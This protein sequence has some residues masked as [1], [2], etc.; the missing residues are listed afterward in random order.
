MYWYCGV[1]DSSSV[2]GSGILVGSRKMNEKS[3]SSSGAWRWTPGGSFAQAGHLGSDSNCWL[4]IKWWFWQATHENHRIQVYFIIPLMTSKISAAHQAKWAVNI[5]CFYCVVWHW[6]SVSTFALPSGLE[7]KCWW[8]FVM[9]GSKHRYEHNMPNLKM[10]HI[11]SKFGIRT[12]VKLLIR[13]FT[14]KVSAD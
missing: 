4:Y 2:C 10:S 6:W 5:I 14:R 7:Q 13:L 1:S 12:F 3:I 11:T 8:R 9:L